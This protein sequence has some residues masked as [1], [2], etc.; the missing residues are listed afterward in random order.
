MAQSSLTTVIIPARGPAGLCTGRENGTFEN[1][2]LHLRFQIP[3]CAYQLADSSAMAQ[4]RGHQKL[5]E[6]RDAREK[7]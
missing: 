3:D 2:G 6:V 4:A 7:F 5:R 1:F